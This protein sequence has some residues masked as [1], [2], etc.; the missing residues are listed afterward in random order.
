MSSNI[1]SCSPVH[2]AAIMLTSCRF[3][4]W[5][6]GVQSAVMVAQYLIMPCAAAELH[7]TE[8]T[9]AH[10]GGRANS[11]RQRQRCLGAVA[12]CEA[13]GDGRCEAVTAADSVLHIHLPRNGGSCWKRTREGSM[14]CARQ[15]SQRICRASMCMGAAASQT[16]N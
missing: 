10:G 3:C 7:A 5:V 11:I 6:V 12:P 4:L 9:S 16:C 2:D 8:R 1:R 14:V 13:Q 15:A